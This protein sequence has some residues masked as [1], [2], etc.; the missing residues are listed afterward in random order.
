MRLNVAKRYST[1]SPKCSKIIFKPINI[2]ITPPKTSALL[3][4]S[5][6]VLLPAKTPKN[7]KA[8]VTVAIIIQ[9]IPMLIL[10]KRANV[11]PTASASI[12]VAIAKK[13]NSLILSD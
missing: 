1:K 2:R 13:N 11:M 7:D 6:P 9:H 8:N 10:G 3:F 5:S 12:E 4:K